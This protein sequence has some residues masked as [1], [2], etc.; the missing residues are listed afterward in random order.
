MY[1]SKVNALTNNKNINCQIHSNNNTISY[2]SL[3]AN[4]SGDQITFKGIDPITA[5][6]LQ[7]AAEGAASILFKGMK[8]RAVVEK[9]DA[10]FGKFDL[11]PAIETAVQLDAK[12]GKNFWVDTSRILNKAITAATNLS[13]EHLVNRDLK[14]SVL[15]HCY[16]DTDYL[17]PQHRNAAERLLKSL[18][19]TTYCEF[20]KYLFSR[21]AKDLTRDYGSIHPGLRYFDDLDSVTNGV[22]DESFRA[23]LRTRKMEQAAEIDKRSI[24]LIDDHFISNQA[25]SGG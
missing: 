5:T 18:N 8:L 3:K 4:K 25:R 21:L 22:G 9:A 11:K 1:I 10:L 19:N 24:D 6:I 23:F 17:E 12:Y 14:Q 16:I 7:E 2:S 15:D 13:D 20:K